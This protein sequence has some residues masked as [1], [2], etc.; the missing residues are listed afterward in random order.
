[1]HEDIT[2][3]LLHSKSTDISDAAA[4][5]V[6]EMGQWVGGVLG[7]LD[8]LTR[9]GE[10]PQAAG[11]WM[12]IDRTKSATLEAATGRTKAEWFGLLVEP[13]RRYVA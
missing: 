6:D 9:E 2:S 7:L 4:L 3:H 13:E 8:R 11:M 5:A 1:M 12:I 10:D